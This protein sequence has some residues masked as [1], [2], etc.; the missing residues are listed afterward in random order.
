MRS[1]DAA[2]LS[3]Y[4]STW[5][6]S[7]TWHLLKRQ[8]LP[9]SRLLCLPLTCNRLCREAAP[10][11]A[12]SRTLSSES[13]VLTLRRLLRFLAPARTVPCVAVTPPYLFDTIFKSTT[14][15]Q[16]SHRLWSWPARGRPL[17]WP[18]TRP[19]SSIKNFISHEKKVICRGPNIAR[20]VACSSSQPV[21]ARSHCRRPENAARPPKQCGERP[22]ELGS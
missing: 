9:S 19:C 22:Q 4:H 17:N 11:H 5:K 8:S 16:H 1:A 12:C 2:V 3:V 20:E 21:A 7:S 15:I 6:Q 10:R 13:T 14:A 18:T